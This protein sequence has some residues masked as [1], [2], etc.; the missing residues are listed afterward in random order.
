MPTKTDTVN[1]IEY[2]KGL[3]LIPQPEVF[4]LHNN[5]DITKDNQETLS[6]CFIYLTQ[7]WAYNV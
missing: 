4:G 1:I 7:T 2:V 3:P 6:V 5:A